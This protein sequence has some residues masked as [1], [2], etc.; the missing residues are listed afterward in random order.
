M[1]LQALT[2]IVG[3]IHRGQLETGFAPE[4][5]S[6]V[7]HRRERQ[8]RPERVEP[9]PLTEDLSHL[10]KFINGRKPGE[11][12]GRE[13]ILRRTRPDL[14]PVYASIFDRGESTETIAKRLGLNRGT[15]SATICGQRGERL[16]ALVA[17]ALTKEER[18][19]LGWV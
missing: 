8:D 3:P 13:E 10:N 17:S 19:M 1:T 14:R 16:K 5:E 2:S 6:T 12:L 7:P 18:K 9:P 11:K 4:Q 15:V